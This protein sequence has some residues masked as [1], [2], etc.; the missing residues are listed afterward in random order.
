MIYFYIPQGVLHFLRD[1]HLDMAAFSHGGSRCILGG[2]RTFRRDSLPL[3]MPFFALLL[4][5]TEE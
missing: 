5:F 3:R 4:A 1:L 2:A